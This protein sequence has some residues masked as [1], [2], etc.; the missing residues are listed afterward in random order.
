MRGDDEGEGGGRKDSLTRMKG[1][2]GGDWL[3]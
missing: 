3:R 2:V 1:V